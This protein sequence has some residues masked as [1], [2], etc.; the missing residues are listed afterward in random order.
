M[1]APPRPRAACSSMMDAFAEL[2][3]CG[4][5]RKM[6]T[7]PGS[8]PRPHGSSTTKED[9]LPVTPSSVAANTLS[10]RETST[11]ERLKH[12]LQAQALAR[13]GFAAN[14]SG[15]TRGALDHFL[16]AILLDP[17][18][19]NY[20]LSAGNMHLK[21]GGAAEATD[22]YE[23]CANLPLSSHQRTM[24]HKKLELAYVM[25]GQSTARA[26]LCAALME[27][28]G[29]ATRTAQGCTRQMAD[30]TIAALHVSS[31]DA[32]TDTLEDSADSHLD[33]RTQ[34]PETSSIVGALQA[35]ASHAVMALRRSR[36]A[37]MDGVPNSPFTV[38][39]YTE[40]D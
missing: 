22:M 37:Q 32:Q 6:R 13:A 10:M 15:D 35:N 33:T 17:I 23:R 34:A 14:D 31:F 5:P 24:L 7:P 25:L 19:P 18:T 3:G 38:D 4:P 20:L 21:L 30:T 8:P 12:V 11:T 1:N 28:E 16:R 40:V 39:G 2:L 9:G 26:A 29:T 27:L 36:Q